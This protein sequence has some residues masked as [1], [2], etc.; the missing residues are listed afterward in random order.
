MKLPTS[1]WFRIPAYTLL[2]LIVISAGF[3]AFFK[4]KTKVY[5]K[6][7]HNRA[8]DFVD[9]TVFNNGTYHFPR[10]TWV[11]FENPAEL[12]WNVDSL[13]KVPAAIEEFL[14]TGAFMIVHKG[15]LIEDWGNTDE[16]YV[17]QSVRK[18]LLNGLL[19][20]YSDRGIIDINSTLEELNID[21]NE[22]SLTAEEKQSAI[23]DL[24]NTTSGIYH[25]ALYEVGSWKRNKPDRGL[26]SPGEVWYYNNWDFNALGTIFEQESNTSIG[27]AFYNEFGLPL[28]MQDFKPSDVQ[29]LSQHSLSERVLDNSSEHKAYMFNITARDMARYGL[30]FL[31]GGKWNDKQIVSEEWIQES[32]KGLPKDSSDVMYI[33]DQVYNESQTYGMLWWKVI[34]GKYSENSKF[35]GDIIYASGNG[36]QKIIL[37]P[38]LDL[39]VVHLVPTQGLGFLNQIKRGIFR[40]RHNVGDRDLG[41]LLEYIRQAHPHY[42]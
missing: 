37:I 33:F 41:I 27:D 38:Y 9:I 35:E 13:K 1:K 34:D 2:T 31:N 42:Q 5:D 16:K 12:G 36:G 29:Y 39:V 17:S 15:V 21:D 14:D 4:H 11:E 10:E 26:H 30:L 7:T 24:M 8:S 28:Q 40:T 32:F 18:S 22:P 3:Y 23:R 20:I 25:S 6:L 19:G